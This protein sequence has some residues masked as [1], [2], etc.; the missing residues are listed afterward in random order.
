MAE[1]CNSI[2]GIL[3]VWG[4]FLAEALVHVFGEVLGAEGVAM[5][6]RHGGGGIAKVVL[7][8]ERVVFV[9]EA[10]V[11]EVTKALMP[12]FSINNHW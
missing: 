4:C 1:Q 10:P 2:V 6:N 5:V 8:G 7:N 3:E 11:C 9:F 12:H